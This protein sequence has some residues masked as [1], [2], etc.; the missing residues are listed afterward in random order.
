MFK[1]YFTIAMRNLMRHKVYTFINLSGLATGMTCC[2]LILLYIQYE[3]SFDRHHEKADRI[4]KV[5]HK[6]QGVEK[7]FYATGA[8]SPLAATLKKEIPEVEHA[9][10]LLIRSM[11]LRQEGKSFKRMVCLSDPDILK[12]FTFPLIK[13]NAVT[14]LDTPYSAFISQ[15]VAEEFF[16]NTD[17]IGQ[18]LQVDHKWV[19]GDFIVTGILANAPETTTW[20]TSFDFLTTTAPPT[21][22]IQ[23]RWDNWRPNANFHD[24][25]T[26]LLLKEGH[27]PKT[28][29][30]KIPNVLRPH[31]GDDYLTQNTHHLL[32]LTR[33][34]LFARSDY[35]ITEFG[36]IQIVYNLALM[37]FFILII[38]CVNFMN[39]STARSANRARE[40]GIRKVVG[41]KKP[42]LI[43]Q[44]LGES[45]IMATLALILALACV[46][47]LLPYLNAF[48]FKSLSM[49]QDAIIGLIA[50][51]FFVGILGGLYPAIFLSAYHPI[52]V[53]KGVFKRGTKNVTMR[54]GLVVF[55]FTLAALMITGTLVSSQQIA[56]L[57][58]K[59]LG[60]E[61]D[62]IIFLTP[63]AA[64]PD[65]IPM[66]ESVRQDFL[67]YTNVI[68]ASVSHLLP[69]NANT[70]DQNPVR[71]SHDIESQYM[72]TIGVDDAFLETY[73]IPLI[74]GQNF[75]SAN[76]AKSH[77]LLNETAARLLGGNTVL[78]K[79]IMV[80]DE[81]YHVLGIVKDFHNLSLYENIGPMVMLQIAQSNP[82]FL[83]LHIKKDNIPETLAFIKSKWETYIPDKPFEFQ[84][85]DAYYQMRYQSITHTS[86]MV[87][88]L[89]LLAIFVGCLG[90]LGLIEFTAEQRTKEI[91]IRKIVG[92]S[93][94][95]LIILLSRELIAL[96]IIAN[97]I[98]LPISFYF[99]NQWLHNFAYR[100][101]LGVDLFCLSIFLTLCIAS[102]TVG[103]K[104]L[105]AAR[106]NPVDAL[107]YE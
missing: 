79:T 46:E 26:Y 43:G 59:N 8:M 51:T 73:K 64:N 93:E 35:G 34:H 18:V 68:N 42:Q 102:A 10:R 75:R 88:V 57:N 3:F 91:G 39:L 98:A 54:K 19:K 61:K 103:Y 100:I 40:V 13:G 44:F 99:L 50:L 86:D 81:P 16:G 38:A 92:A 28:V 31:L 76:P 6:K 74:E 22:F 77:V 30:S 7:T 90:L 71:L 32:P 66:S 104:A 62:H 101:Q 25:K 60:F 53:L 9:T 85:L 36:D 20:E 96:V 83:S 14:G 67:Q 49:S 84:F 45:L 24:F 29:E 65:L 78:G 94:Y 87:R 1:N 15:R 69:G 47:F 82:Y 11:W 80:K 72:F 12:I 5:L 33:L 2:I 4:Y 52:Q 63:F 55:Q 89:S 48:L 105:K 23:T 17:P 70:H 106:N 58:N 37:G 56:Y 107:R 97:L 41:A 95:N 21:R 27:S